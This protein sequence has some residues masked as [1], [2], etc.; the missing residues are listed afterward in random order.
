MSRP[1]GL[2]KTGGRIRGTPNRKTDELAAKLHGLG[3]DPIEGLARIAMDAA[4]ALELKVRC[5]AELAQYVHAKRK[6]VERKSEEDNELRV[7]VERVGG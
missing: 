2:P 5:Y 6:A 3:C 4:T 7:I 1:K